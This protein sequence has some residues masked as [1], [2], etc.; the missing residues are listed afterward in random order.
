LRDPTTY[1]KVNESFK[2]YLQNLRILTQTRLKGIWNFEDI[3]N[4]GN[5]FTYF[6]KQQIV[7][8]CEK[9]EKKIVIYFESL[10]KYLRENHQDLDFEFNDWSKPEYE[11]NLCLNYR[12]VIDDYY[13]P[14][15]FTESKN[16]DRPF[17]DLTLDFEDDQN[18]NR[19]EIVCLDEK[20]KSR[21]YCGINVIWREGARDTQTTESKIY[22]DP[23]IQIRFGRFGSLPAMGITREKFGE[24]YY[25]MITYLVET[26]F[27][28]DPKSL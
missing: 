24:Q 27:G 13:S 4:T 9:Y 17:Y 20:S 16:G 3:D 11:N 7:E 22:S 8:N 15:S 28:I 14:L 10:A 12:M 18:L 5:R 26:H 1:K 25:Q 2:P 19:I 6:E 21:P 23:D